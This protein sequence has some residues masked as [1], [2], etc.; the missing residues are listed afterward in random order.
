MAN[1]ERGGKYALSGAATGAGIGS[2]FSPAGTAIGAGIG[3]LGGGLY[4]LFSDDPEPF[5]PNEAVGARPSAGIGAEELRRR[6]LALAD[7]L[8]ARVRGEGVSPAELQMQ[9]GLA[10]QLAGIN[11]MAASGAGAAN[12]GLAL[13]QSLYAG[14][15]AQRGFNEDAAILRAQEQAAAESRL[16]AHLGQNQSAAA[17]QAA[18]NDTMLRFERGIAYDQASRDKQA[19]RDMLA[20]GFETGGTLLNL[21]RNN[22]SKANQSSQYHLADG[23]IVTGPTRAVVGEGGRPEAVVPLTSPADAALAARM[24]EKARMR[25]AAEDQAR[26]LA[27]LV[28]RFESG[29]KVHRASAAALQDAAERARSLFAPQ[30]EGR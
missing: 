17:N 16:A 30:A 9:R 2:A 12:P 22:L 3:A 28:G 5:V 26:A 29:G 25:M 13:R 11:A 23:G 27:A 18:L 4:G 19:E 15:Q 20:A 7:T 10:Q 14:G 6:H 1:W 21:N 24:I 8:E